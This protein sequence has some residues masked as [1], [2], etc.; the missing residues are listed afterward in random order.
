MAVRGRAVQVVR[1]IIL[2]CIFTELSPLNHLCFHNG[3][4]SGPY[5]GKY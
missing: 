5:L 2:P 1:T 3:F 4:L